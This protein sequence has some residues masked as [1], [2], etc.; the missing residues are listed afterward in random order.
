MVLIRLDGRSYFVKKLAKIQSAT[1]AAARPQVSFSIKSTDLAA[2]NIW[3]ALAPPNVLS[4]PP[5]FGFWI[6]IMRASSM[7]IK[8]ARITSVMNMINILIEFLF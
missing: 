6:K 4:I 2:P 1:R 3:L 5:P 7:Q 8:I